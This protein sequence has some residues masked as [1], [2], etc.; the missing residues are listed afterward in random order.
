MIVNCS[1]PPRLETSH[2]HIDTILPFAIAIAVIKDDLLTLELA[3]SVIKDDHPTLYKST[4]HFN[5]LLQLSDQ[6]EDDEASNCS[7]H[8]HQDRQEGVDK[9]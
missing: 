7:V 8:C 9:K 4:V 6:S 3:H 2:C 1:L 5:P